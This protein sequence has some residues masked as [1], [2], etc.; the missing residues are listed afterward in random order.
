MAIGFFA[1]TL[2]LTLLSEIAARILKAPS[3][4]FLI[5]GI[6]PL[7]PG[8]GIFKTA[9]LILQNRVAEASMTGNATAAELLFMVAGIAIVSVMFKTKL[10][11]QL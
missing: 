8:A 3:T 2:T 6:Y 11:K 4:V 1:A 7:V 10:N 9:A 5:I